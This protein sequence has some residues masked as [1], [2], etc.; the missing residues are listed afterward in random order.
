MPS[1]LIRIIEERLS[2]CFND[3]V[4]INSLKNIGGGCVSNA[5]KLGTNV[6]DF[7]LK[8]N[9]NCKA[10]MFLREVEGLH[11]LKKASADVLK[12]PKVFCVKEVDLTSGF[13]VQEYLV[14]GNSNSA[15]DEQLGRGLATI[16][17][18]TNEKIWFL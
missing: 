4:V 5:S 15:N 3:K 8:W 1:Q 6:G 9:A 17:T 14:P 7:F 11:E 10:D 12:I 16:H 13:L 2:L 18:Y